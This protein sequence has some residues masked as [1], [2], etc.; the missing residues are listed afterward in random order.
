MNNLDTVRVIR[1]DLD[2]VEAM[3]LIHT[4][5]DSDV[6]SPEHDKFEALIT[7]VQEYDRKKRP[8]PTPEVK[9]GRI[10]AR[11]HRWCERLYFWL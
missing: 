5:W 4:L 9:R 3:Y 11:L 6:G 8:E 7:L 10:R 1:T 2:R